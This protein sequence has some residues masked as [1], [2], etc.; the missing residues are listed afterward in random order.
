[1]IRFTIS[2]S[3]ELNEW[4]KAQAK[5]YN[6]SKN[7]HIAFL[8]QAIRET[9]EENQERLASLEF[10]GL[11]TCITTGHIDSHTDVGCDPLD[12]EILQGG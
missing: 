3:T 9:A 6:R 10:P 12:S 4:L 1:M 5:Y 7:Q 8:L 11:N 2:I